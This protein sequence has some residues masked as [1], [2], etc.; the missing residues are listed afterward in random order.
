M[1]EAV[2]PRGPLKESKMSQLKQNAG[3]DAFGIQFLTGLSNVQERSKGLSKD[4]G[5]SEWRTRS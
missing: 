1:Y 2:Q 4:K 3:I 5:L